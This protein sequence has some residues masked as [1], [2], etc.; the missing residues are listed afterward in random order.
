[1]EGPHSARVSWETVTKPKTHGGLGIKDLGTWNK[2]CYLRMIWLLFFQAV[3]VWVVWFRSEVL[4]GCLRKYWTM[5]TNPKFSWLVNKLIK[6]RDVVFTWIK[7]VGNGRCCRVWTDNWSPYGS[8]ELF[9]HHASSNSRFGIPKNATL[10]DLLLDGQWSL[11]PARSEEFL[12]VQIYLTTLFITEEEDTYDWVLT[13]SP[14]ERYSTGEVYKILRDEGDEV[15]WVKVVWISGGVPK[16]SFL[17]WL[18]ILNRCPTRDR[19]LQWG[20]Q[21]DSVCLLCNGDAELRDHLLFFCPYSWDLW[22][23]ISNRCG[24]TPTRRW[25]DSVEQMQNLAGNK[26]RKR[27][28]YIGWQALI[29]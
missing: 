25:N 1:M 29:Y 27:L 18:F 7:V 16:H 6:M 11:P 5:K 20:L 17:T 12:Q 4:D 3:S 9:M 23:T 8:L 26:L 21:T 28:T 14:T 10:S 22:Q 13:D 19:L 2:A 24:L 15:S